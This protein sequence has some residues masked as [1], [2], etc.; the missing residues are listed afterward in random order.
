MLSDDSRRKSYDQ[1]GSTDNQFQGFENEDFFRGFEGFKSGGFDE[2]S[3][4]GFAEMFMGGGGG[5]RASRAAQASLNINLDIDFFEGVNGT[6]KVRSH[7]F[8]L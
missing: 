1:T 4:A 6:Q 7:P 3:F 8:R 5:R 2:S